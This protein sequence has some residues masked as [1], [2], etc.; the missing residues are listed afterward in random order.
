VTGWTRICLQIFQKRPFD[1]PWL[2]IRFGIAG[3]LL[4]EE[5]PELISDVAA[6]F[7]V[8]VVGGFG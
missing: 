5:F 7:A 3:L 4:F 8:E 6:C 2:R 1:G